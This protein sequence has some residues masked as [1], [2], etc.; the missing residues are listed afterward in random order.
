MLLPEID[1][2]ARAAAGEVPSPT[3]PQIATLFN[4]VGLAPHQKAAAALQALRRWAQ[5]CRAPQAE[6]DHAAMRLA[7]LAAG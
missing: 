4:A 2:L 1:A 5:D 3:D 7:G 6:R